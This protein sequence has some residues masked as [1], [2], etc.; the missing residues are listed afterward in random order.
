MT[1]TDYTYEEGVNGATVG[2]GNGVDAVLGAPKYATAAAVHATLGVESAGSNQYLRYTVPASNSGSVYVKL[3]ASTTGANR[4]LVW[5]S[6]GNAIQVSFRFGTGTTFTIADST[7]TTVGAASTTTWAV[8]D[9]FRF[10]WQYESP[11]ANSATITVRIFKG[12]NAEGATPNETITRTVTWGTGTTTSKLRVGSSLAS[13]TVRHDTLRTSDVLEWIG[14]YNPS[15]P[16][17]TVEHTWVGTPSQ[18]GFVVTARTIG[19]TSVR[20][21]VSASSDMA[22]PSDIGPVTPDTDGYVRFDAA[23]LSAGTQYWYRLADTPAGGT[24][25]PIGN[26][27]KARTLPAV[28]SPQ[29]F[30]VALGACTNGTKNDG[31]AHASI[32]AWNPDFMVHTGDFYYLN[33]ESLDPSTY[34]GAYQNQ[35]ETYP[36][37]DV[38]CRDI[39]MFYCISDHECGLDNADSNNA[40]NTVHDTVYKQVAPYAGGTVRYHTWV[41]GR[42]RFILLDDKTPDRSPWANTDNSSKTMLGATQKAW[43]FT[44][45]SQPQPLKVIIS[46]VPW[47]GPA[48]TTNGEDKWWVYSTERAEIAA[49]IN[50]NLINVDLWHGDSHALGLTG[51]AGNDEGGFPVV[52]SAPLAN[53]GGGRNNAEHDLLYST[54]TTGEARQYMRITFT[55]DG[56]TITRT[57]SGWDALNNVQRIT[58]TTVWDTA[59]TGTVAYT[60]TGDTVAAAGTSVGPSS[61]G[62]LTY[63][64]ASDTLSA[65]GDATPPALTGTVAYTD[66][67]DSVAAAGDATPPP[68]TADVG[69]TD[70]DDTIAAA[71]TVTPPAFT[72]TVAYTDTG[73]TIAAAGESTSTGIAGQIAYTDTG[74]SIAAAGTTVPPSISGTVTYTDIGDTVAAAGLL[75]PGGTIAYTDDNDSVDASGVV[76]NIIT[77]TVTWTDD[78]DSFVA[79]GTVVTTTAGQAAWTDA[80]DTL[81][82]A[83]NV[84]PP[85][86]TAT[87]VF[88]DQGDLVAAVG[89]FALDDPATLT[90]QLFAATLLAVDLTPATTLDTRL[91]PA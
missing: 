31:A 28:G 66:A 19:A 18:T 3:N 67:A 40:W 64:D 5:L 88:T 53:V 29:S 15:A 56:A 4:V 30:T 50:N 34:R 20:L 68:L 91:E 27:G 75:E 81:T 17:G 14:A 86:R 76:V 22:S 7:S 42:V 74:D 83:G 85:S 51:K 82:A 45:L 69:Y 63:T 62:T 60:D 61:T 71:G 33:T 26:V 6:S 11:A 9:L 10:D 77:G 32:V 43:L 41:V 25:T 58:Q 48:S 13:W 44:Q 49:Y 16:A 65:A 24:E 79:A 38:L 37:H 2:V 52:Q 23:G 39:P 12:A 55:D 72:G 87:I 54:G 1:I 46:D 78:V 90:V 36:S 59:F 47:M 21:A 73:D 35:I 89:S 70:V 80:G 8:G 57:A 84:V